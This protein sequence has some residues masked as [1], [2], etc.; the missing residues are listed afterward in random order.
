MII[1]IRLT[2][3]INII[4]RLNLMMILLLT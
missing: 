2:M 3:I 1:I 4:I